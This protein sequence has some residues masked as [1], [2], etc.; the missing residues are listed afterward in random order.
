MKIFSS[1]LPLHSPPKRE[2]ESLGIPI[3]TTAEFASVKMYVANGKVQEKQMV[4]NRVI[5]IEENRGW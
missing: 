2:W 4:C 5:A 3:I 1:P